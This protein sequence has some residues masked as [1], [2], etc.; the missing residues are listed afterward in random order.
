LP[1][2]PTITSVTAGNGSIIVAFTPPSNTGGLPITS[3][4]VTASPGNFTATGTAS[5]ITI[6]GLTNGTAYT[7]TAKAT[8][9]F[10]TSV[11][12][13]PSASVTPKGPPNPPTNLVASAS[14]TLGDRASVSFTAPSSNGGS[15]IT[16]YTVTS[17]PGNFTAT[18]AA[19]PIIVTGLTAGTSY[20]FKATATNIV[21]TS[22]QSAASASFKPIGKPGA[23][24]ITGVVGSTGSIIVSFNPP[25]F[26]GGT[27][28]TSYTATSNPGNAIVSGPSSPLTITGLTV[29]STYTVTVTATN[30][31]GTGPASAASDPVTVPNAS[32]P[33]Y[34]LITYTGTQYVD[35]MTG[36]VYDMTDGHE[37]DPVTGVVMVPAP[38]PPGPPV[39]EMPLEALAV[40]FNSASGWYMSY[41][42]TYVD[43]SFEYDVNFN[44]LG[45]VIGPLVVVTSDGRCVNYNVDPT[46]IVDCTSLTPLTGIPEPWTPLETPAPWVL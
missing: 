11:P 28:I 38:T 17:S 24:T 41:R 8:T 9:S 43:T 16:S 27:A 25:S 3:Y 5:P 4:S 23:P 19:S 12:S 18:G 35:V 15:P 45:A 14:G 36:Y 30:I 33:P 29:G 22:A 7:V 13:A 32:P 10:G 26:T 39:V 37:T 2:P 21:G 31:V 44:P 34:V 46:V 6:T 42:D 40:S 1:S 20:T